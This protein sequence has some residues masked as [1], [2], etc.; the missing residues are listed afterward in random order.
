MDINS[1]LLVGLVFALAV[2]FYLVLKLYRVREQISFIKDAL[3]DLKRGNLNRRVLAQ[4]NDMTKQICY[5]INE[6]AISSQTQLIHQKQSEQAYKRL[7][8]S[9][10][11]DV[12]TPLASLVGYLEAIE[13]NIVT[14]K[15]KDEYLHVAYEK[16][17]HLKHFVEN[18]FEWVK[19]DSGE[20]AFHFENTDLN[21]L[22][23]N[24]IADWVPVLESSNFEY[25]FTIPET[26]Y[27]VRIDINAYTRILN[28]LLQNTITHSEGSKMTLQ[29]V[30]SRQK[31]KIVIADNGKGISSD[32]LPHIF[33]RLYQCDHSRSAKGNGLGLAIA[34]EL[35]AVHKGTITADST[36]GKGTEFIISLPKA[37]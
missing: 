9:L 19:L 37:L 11:H 20:Q 14:G 27:T 29:I 35:V 22:T 36:P 32:N 25:E 3:E 24:I 26:E 21:E 23:R 10:S 31:A 33:E 2:I 28:N 4:E 15:E 18:L 12:K 13:S 16:S 34:K 1:Y 30:E 6:I 8:T 17:Q 5:D 7:I